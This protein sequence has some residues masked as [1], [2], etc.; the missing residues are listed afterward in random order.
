M[1]DIWKIVWKLWFEQKSVAGGGGK[2]P[3]AATLASD[4]VSWTLGGV[5]RYMN[6]SEVDIDC[7]EEALGRVSV[8]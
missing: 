2:W 8:Y 4:L 7:I 1:T 5:Q 3:A 6:K